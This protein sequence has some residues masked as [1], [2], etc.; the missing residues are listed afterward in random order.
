MRYKRR[1]R[2]G[3]SALAF[4][5]GV[6]F[7]LPQA[8]AVQVDCGAVLGPGGNFVLDSDVGPCSGPE[9]ALTL[10]SATLDL[11]DHTVSCLIPTVYGIDMEGANSQVHN[12]TVT[13]CSN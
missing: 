7:S 10:I 5:W 1:W 6:G 3:I 11:A 12:G 8:H 13:G 4:I 2:Y 9:P